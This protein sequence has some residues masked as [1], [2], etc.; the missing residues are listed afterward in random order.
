MANDTLQGADL[1]VAGNYASGVLPAADD[2]LT[3]PSSLNA[4]VVDSTPALITIDLDFLK[5]MPG[6]TGLFGSS[7][8]PIRFAADRID[9][10]GSSGFYFECDADT[11]ATPDLITDLI[12]VNCPNANTPVELGSYDSDSTA[13]RGVIT[14]INIA[15]GNVLIKS[16][17][18]FDSS[19]VTLCPTNYGDAR[20]EIAANADTLEILLVK[21]GYSKANNVVTALTVDAGATHVQDVA[22][23]TTANVYGALMMN[24]GANLTGTTVATT[25]NMYEGCTVNLFG[26][27]QN[28]G[29]T[30]YKTVTTINKHPNSTLIY[31][32]TVHT[33]T[34][35]NVWAI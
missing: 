16:N 33:I 13:A 19:T 23:V 1:S 20:L 6:F 12:N 5:V 25:I 21:N 4:N 29:H 22:A 30:P 3:I 14:A 34:N 26:D 17:T 32:S 15:K 35:L 8:S 18:I 24:Y 28:A 31:D 10:F 7:G 27:G 11:S 2:G 9:V